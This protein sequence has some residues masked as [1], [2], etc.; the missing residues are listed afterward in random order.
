[1]SLNLM[2]TVSSELK[3]LKVKY[4]PSGDTV[5]DQAQWIK[6]WIT[7]VILMTLLYGLHS[8]LPVGESGHVAD[9]SV[10]PTLQELIPPGHVLIPIEPVN[11]EALDSVLDSHGIVDLFSPG[12]RKQSQVVLSGVAIVRAPKN[13]RQFAVILEDT[14]VTDRQLAA[15][16]EPLY[17]ALRSKAPSGIHPSS[18]SV[19]AIQVAT[20]DP[21][22]TSSKRLTSQK[23]KR[24]LHGHENRLIVISEFLD[25]PSLTEE[26]SP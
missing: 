5:E 10:S 20:T 4:F 6:T 7:A 12:A 19:N 11:A 26:V 21:P 8:A 23:S 3:K 15:L 18:E 2:F 25:E 9:A 13:P 17:V 1:M 14:K 22:T 24:R 16:T